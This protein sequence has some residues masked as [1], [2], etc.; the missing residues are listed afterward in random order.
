M[1][2]GHIM[3]CATNLFGRISHFV[4]N[5]ILSTN[6]R[7]IAL[8]YFIFTFITGFSGLTLATIIRIE[9]AYTGQVILLGN[10][11]KYLTIVSLH[12]IIMVFFVVIPILFGAFGNFLLPTQLGIRDVAFP[13]LNSFMFWI[14]PA[15]F[16]M[17]LHILL[18]DKSYNLTYWLNYS[19]LRAQ[20]RR[21]YSVASSQDLEYHL[22]SDNSLLAL[23]LALPSERKDR[24]I[25]SLAAAEHLTMGSEFG[26]TTSWFTGGSLYKVFSGIMSYA[27]SSFGFAA[28]HNATNAALA[29]V[30]AVATYAVNSL[31]LLVLIPARIV[32][33]SL[34]LTTESRGLRIYSLSD[35]L[36]G[37][38]RN[39]LVCIQNN[40]LDLARYSHEYAGLSFLMSALCGAGEVSR[41]SLNFVNQDDFSRYMGWHEQSYDISLPRDSRFNLCG[42]VFSNVTS[43]SSEEV[44]IED[45]SSDMTGSSIFTPSSELYSYCMTPSMSTSS[46]DANQS[47]TQLY[48]SATSFSGLYDSFFNAA[49]L[50]SD[51]FLDN[52]T[53]ARAS[54]GAFSF[55]STTTVSGL[56]GSIFNL[57]YPGSFSSVLVTICFQLGA[58]FY[59]VTMLTGWFT[60]LF[61]KV[62]SFFHGFVNLTYVSEE[63]TH[64][65]ELHFEKR[66]DG[67]TYAPIFTLYGVGANPLTE[68]GLFFGNL[69]S[70]ALAHHLNNLLSP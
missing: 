43:S 7:R 50:T 4:T 12:G 3:L 41:A 32:E 62:S 13:R 59:L 21:R 31:L 2:R 14:T 28:V 60:N 56:S 42:D 18:F 24:A 15:G 27:S 49:A 30:Y 57:V 46:V 22:Q 6:H 36:E 45:V 48:P 68:S 69:L 25:R 64:P 20:L 35:S 34:F 65:F 40:L 61:A 29:L 58:P 44:Q 26:T 63:L 17:L 9:L 33:F 38:I 51:L 54:V 52:N 37:Y 39:Y 1:L 10:A 19:E 67:L 53:Q 23:R 5:W 55:A 16:V 47:T 66:A 70:A 8:M 11:E